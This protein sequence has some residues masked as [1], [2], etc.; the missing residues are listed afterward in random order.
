SNVRSSPAVAAIAAVSRNGKS[1]FSRIADDKAN[2]PGGSAAAAATASALAWA[3]V[4]CSA[5]VATV[6]A[7]LPD[8]DEAWSPTATTT[9]AAV[10]VSARAAA[11][12]TGTASPD[13][14]R[15]IATRVRSRT[16]LDSDRDERDVIP[17]GIR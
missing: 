15:V 13:S 10:M 7:I 9:A 5:A 12:A 17:V 3:C 11:T 8:N 14:A 6:A 2:T 4:V 16:V 1:G